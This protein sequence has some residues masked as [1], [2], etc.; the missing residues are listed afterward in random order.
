MNTPQAYDLRQFALQL[1][2]EGALLRITREVEPRFEL[3]ALLEQLEQ[4]GKA[5]IFE[6][7][8]GAKFPLIGGILD[9]A[10]RLGMAVGQDTSEGYDHHDHYKY[11]RQASAKPIPRASW[12]ARRGTSLGGV[13][14]ANPQRFRALPGLGWKRHPLVT[15]AP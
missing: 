14:D 13:G 2:Q 15:P 8:K 5:Y 12:P 6:N 1:E 11:V 3:P 7:V 4:L 10:E 9:S